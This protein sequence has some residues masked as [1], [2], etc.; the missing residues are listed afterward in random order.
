MA[1]IRALNQFCK[2]LEEPRVELPP[3]EDERI[4]KLNAIFAGDRHGEVDGVI[5]DLRHDLLP[6]AEWSLPLLGSI[7]DIT[8]T[9]PDV[10]LIWAITH[11]QIA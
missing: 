10:P 1:E 11:A 2:S 5:F 9:S 7:A 6:P 4:D 3:D 8:L